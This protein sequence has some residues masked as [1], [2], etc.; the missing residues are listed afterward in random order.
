MNNQ[1]QGSYVALV[2]PFTDSGELDEST[3][4]RLAN[5]QIE[6][7]IDGLVPC[8]TTG[9]S[10][11]LDDNE[12]QRVMRLTIEASAGR[13]PVICG[14]G[15]NN[16]RKVIHMAQTAQH[17]GADA[18]LSVSP[19]YNKPTQE[20]IYAHYAAIA[21]A[22]DI[23][24]ILYNVPGRTGSNISAET[25]LR[26]AD[27]PNIV[28]IKEASGNLGQVMEILR[29]RPQGFS[30]L[31]GDDAL[32]LPML[33]AGA[34]G[35]I[36]VIANQIPDEWSRLVH[37]ALRGDFQSARELHYKYLQLMNLNF[38]EANPVPVKTTMAMMGLLSERVR[39]PLCEISAANRER[40][41][42]ELIALDLLK[43]REMVA[44]LL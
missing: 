15:G 25:T 34:D 17:L 9:E 22:T 37:F 8:G 32:T 28:A 12:Y 11:T 2:T 39:L 23:P 29:R 14:A 5:R 43:E 24:I 31:S 41:R 36:S 33:A 42:T 16:T 10:V 38:V 13:V 1:F 40:L 7:G 21:A 20:G 19:S 26:L 4:V 30:V 18:I 27:I 44:G 6:A 35:V 3:L